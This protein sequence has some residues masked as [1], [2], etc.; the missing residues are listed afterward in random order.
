MIKLIKIGKEITTNWSSFLIWLTYIVGIVA[1]IGHINIW[2]KQI[3]LV[4]GM[5]GQLIPFFLIMTIVISIIG[6]ILFYIIPLW[7][8]INK[9]IISKTEDKETIKELKN[10]IKFMKNIMKKVYE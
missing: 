9:I 4:F 2:N 10:N 1:I 3:T 5:L 7:I 8:W 6:I